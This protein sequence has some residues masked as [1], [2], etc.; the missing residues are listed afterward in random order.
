MDSL[1]KKK[2]DS[3]MKIYKDVLKRKMFLKDCQIKKIKW[4]NL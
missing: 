4:I 1:L 3:S 2:Y